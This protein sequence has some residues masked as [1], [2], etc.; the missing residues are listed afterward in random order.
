VKL[1]APP[2]AAGFSFLSPCPLLAESSQSKCVILG[3]LNVR[4]QEKRTFG[5]PQCY[6]DCS[7]DIF[8]SDGG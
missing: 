2:S 8:G 5:N 6:F 3:D 4:F 1:E 7:G